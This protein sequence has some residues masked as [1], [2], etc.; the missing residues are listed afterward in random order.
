MWKR[1]HASYQAGGLEFAQASRMNIKPLF[2]LR[3]IE[4]KDKII[5]A[6][7]HGPLKVGVFCDEWVRRPDDLLCEPAYKSTLLE[8]ESEGA[9]RVLSKDGRSLAPAAARR[10]LKGKPT[11]ANDYLIQLNRSGSINRK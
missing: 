8:L 9:V 6:L 5:K 7:A 1:G 4:I 10:Q 11:L 2:D 3:G